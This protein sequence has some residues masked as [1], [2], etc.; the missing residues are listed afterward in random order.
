MTAHQTQLV[1]VIIG[2]VALLVSTIVIIRIKH[3]VVMKMNLDL[4]MGE[5]QLFEGYVTRRKAWPK[6]EKEAPDIKI[7]PETDYCTLLQF[8]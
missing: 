4:D 5:Y 7:S 8:V 1:L 3:E 2:G 6:K